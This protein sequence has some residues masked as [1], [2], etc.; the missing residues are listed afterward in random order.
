MSAALVIAGTTVVLLINSIPTLLWHRSHGVNPEVAQRPIEDLDT[1]ALRPV[2]LLAPVPEH[3]LSPLAHLSELLT[4]PGSQSEPYQYLG[5]V[6]VVGV[7]V[8]LVAHARVGGGPAQRRAAPAAPA[9]VPSSSCW[10]PSAWPAVCR[11]WPTPAA[12]PRSAR[13][14][15]SPS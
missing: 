11:G 6:A 14:T 10:P 3:R 8:A 1:Y 5:L 12:W 4:R 7:A 13:G 15:G 9:P 2:Q